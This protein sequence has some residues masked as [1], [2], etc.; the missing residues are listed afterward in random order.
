MKLFR[1][2]ANS[3]SFEKAVQ[4]ETLQF[5]P[6]PTKV[7]YPL[8]NPTYAIDMTTNFIF[9]SLPPHPPPSTPLLSAT[10]QLAQHVLIILI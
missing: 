5:A 6:P 10:T 3:W 8:K 9:I 2:R 4:C 1:S 7:T